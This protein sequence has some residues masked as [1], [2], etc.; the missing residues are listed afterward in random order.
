[1]AARTIELEKALDIVQETSEKLERLSVMDELTGLYNRRGFLNLAKQQISLK[2]RNNNDLLLVFFDMDGLK[3]INDTLG[4]SFGDY[5]IVSLANLLRKAFRGTDIIA[6]IGGDEFVILAAECSGDEYTKI[7]SRL[8]HSV[9][10]F[11]ASSDQKFQLSFSSGAVPFDPDSKFTIE[12]LME[13]ADAELY[14]EKNRKK[15]Q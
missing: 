11:N 5:A 15:H 1:M 2:E 9:D 4:H 3:K 14:K 10:E 8:D 6:R 7:R 12:Q 13:K